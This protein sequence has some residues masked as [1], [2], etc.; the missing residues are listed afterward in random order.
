MELEVLCDSQSVRTSLG[1]SV[2]GT[3]QSHSR[4]SITA[5]AILKKEAQRPSN[6]KQIGGFAGA[7]VG[8]DNRGTG[9]RT[10]L[11]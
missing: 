5:T 4:E 9:N 6:R 11:A 8:I 1:L 3:F 10:V 2:K 7:D